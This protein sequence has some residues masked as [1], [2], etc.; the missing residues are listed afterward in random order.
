VDPRAVREG[1]QAVST[2]Q[3]TIAI[4][5]QQLANGYRKE[6]PTSRIIGICR[7][8]RNTGSAKQY[9][10]VLCGETCPG[11]STKYPRTKRSIA[12]ERE[13]IEMHVRAEI[14]RRM[15]ED[16]AMLLVIECLSAALAWSDGLDVSRGLELA[17]EW[18]R[19]KRARSQ[20]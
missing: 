20:P 11:F 4:V 14:N 16:P 9:G 2:E 17:T 6:H 18:E 15:T 19:V 1:W 7:L 13:H 12:W 3:Q 5:E 10:C 8:V